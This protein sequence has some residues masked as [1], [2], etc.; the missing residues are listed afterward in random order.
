MS[1]S[2]K[3]ANLDSVLPI[4]LSVFC[5]EQ[6]YDPAQEVDEYDNGHDH[7]IVHFAAYVQQ[8]TPINQDKEAAVGTCRL[9]LFPEKNIAKLGR[10]AVLS[11]HRNQRIASKLLNEAHEYCRNQPEIKYVQADCQVAVVPFYS[12]LGYKEIGD[13][14]YDQGQPHQGM[15]KKLD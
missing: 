2:I 6:G 15:V 7:P 9:V 10:V 12:T 11:S 4:R 3:Q 5:D 13:I 14:V 1:I 8:E